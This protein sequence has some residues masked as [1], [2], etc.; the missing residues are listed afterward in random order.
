MTDDR[1]R[2]AV[3]DTYALLNARLNEDDEATR[4]ILSHGEHLGMLG[5]LAELC[6]GL[7]KE[8]TGDPQRHLDRLRLSLER[9]ES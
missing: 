6:V 7:L 1:I 5:G 3:R 2:D 9:G 4:V 8:C